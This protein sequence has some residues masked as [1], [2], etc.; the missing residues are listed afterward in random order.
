MFLYSELRRLNLNCHQ[1]AFLSEFLE[2][3]LVPFGVELN[4]KIVIIIFLIYS[5]QTVRNYCIQSKSQSQHRPLCSEEVCFEANKPEYFCCKFFISQLKG[6]IA[7]RCI[8]Q[9][10]VTCILTTLIENEFSRRETAVTLIL[11]NRL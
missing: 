4:I 2:V 3:R 9:F 10:T 5:L 11:E 1:I 7:K 8:L 6:S